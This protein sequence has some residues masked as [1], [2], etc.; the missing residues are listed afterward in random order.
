MFRKILSLP[1]MLALAAA[2]LLGPCSECEPPQ[3]AE[4]SCCDPAPD[5]GSSCPRPDRTDQKQ[6]PDRHE[7]LRNYA[8]SEAPLLELALEPLGAAPQFAWSRAAQTV[9]RLDVIAPRSEGPPDLY[10]RNG[11]ILI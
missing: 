8:R 3:R 11:A 6:C 1:L 9:S 7:I 5:E 2:V 4:H 10:L